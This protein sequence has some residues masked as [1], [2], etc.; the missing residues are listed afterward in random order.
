[1][2]K[3]RTIADDVYVHAD[4]QQIFSL[5]V[6][7]IKLFSVVQMHSLARDTL[8]IENLFMLCE[9]HNRITRDF[10]GGNYIV[11]EC[12]MKKRNLDFHEIMLNVNRVKIKVSGYRNFIA[13]YRKVVWS[14]KWFLRLDNLK[15]FLYI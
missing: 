12:V 10:S 7:P 1:M 5:T 3:T 6:F 13:I 11:R 8:N 2:F 9:K 14:L 4:C 15:C